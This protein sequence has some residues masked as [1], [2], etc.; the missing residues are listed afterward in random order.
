VFEMPTS[1]TSAEIA[2]PPP[3]MPDVSPLTLVVELACT[4]IAR[5]PASM[6][7]PDATK[8]S[9]VRVTRVTDFAPAPVMPP[10]LATRV[11]GVALM[12][13]VAPMSSPLAVIVVAP[14][15]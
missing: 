12:V 15:A 2:I 11:V 13:S 9:V 1:T 5:L 7:P 10:T 8:A 3:E 6:L 14:P 4:P